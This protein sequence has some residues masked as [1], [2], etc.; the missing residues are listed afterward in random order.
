[1]A[2]SSF[3]IGQRA[4]FA[5][6]LVD[7]DGGGTDRF[8]SHRRLALEKKELATPSWERTAR[9]TTKIPVYIARSNVVQFGCAM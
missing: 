3:K 4:A 9:P 5:H 6:E 1:M 2:V 8:C 7:A